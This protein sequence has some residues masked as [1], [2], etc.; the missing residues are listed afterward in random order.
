MV[1]GGPEGGKP[2]TIRDVARV[3]GVS[4]SAVARALAPVLG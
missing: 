3:A 2:P 4:K 1:V